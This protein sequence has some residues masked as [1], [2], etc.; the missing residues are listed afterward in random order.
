MLSSP[1]K[2]EDLIPTPVGSWRY[3]AVTGPEI[4]VQGQEEAFTTL[5][6]HLLP[7]PLRGFPSLHTPSMKGDP[8]FEPGDG[9]KE[10][11]PTVEK[12]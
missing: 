8:L 10:T 11:L 12:G 2:S 4:P 5:L 6:S 7:I 1:E 3:P 9:A